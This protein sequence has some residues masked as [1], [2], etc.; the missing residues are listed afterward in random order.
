MS[1]VLKAM[2]KGGART[3]NDAISNAS[4]GSQILDYFAKCGSYRGRTQSEVNSSLASIF[5]E[6]IELATRVVFYN[7]MVTR[8]CKGFVEPTDNIQKG[9]GQK[10][11]FIKSLIWLENNRPEVLYKNLW[12]IPEI[13]CWKDLW[14]DSPT[15]GLYHYINTNEVYKL[16]KEGMQDEYHQH[17]IAKFLPKIRSRRNTKTD[18]HRRLNN[19]ARGQISR[20]VRKRLS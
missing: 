4:S 18:R 13:G 20:L 10:D 12:L 15:T 9:Q 5:G 6:D 1:T 17:L 2:N 16:V 3:W 7:R 14:Y 11:E 19:W 8:K